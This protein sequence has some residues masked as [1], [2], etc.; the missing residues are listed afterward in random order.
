MGSNVTGGITVCTVLDVGDFAG[1]N[2]E[3]IGILS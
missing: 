1:L 3:I 2:K